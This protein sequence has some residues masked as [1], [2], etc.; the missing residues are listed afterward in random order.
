MQTGSR[1]RRSARKNGSSPPHPLPTKTLVHR[2]AQS[3]H[4]GR[5]GSY[6]P[7]QSNS[8]GIR[9]AL[10]LSSIWSIAAFL[11]AILVVAPASAHEVKL[12]DLTLTDLWTRATPPQAPTAGG[13]LTIANAGAEPDRLIA[14]SSPLAAK[15]E[16]HVMAMKDSVMTMRPVEGGIEIPAGGKVTLEPDGLHIMFISPTEPYKEGGKLPVTLT[17]EK[18]GK[19]DTFLHVLAI[20][21]K[22]YDA[23]AM[24]KMKMSP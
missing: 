14:A 22:A 16:L 10:S 5:G 9:Q 13:Y 21:A 2:I 15:T 23:Q 11:L 24:S 19:V 3:S 7:R 1:R 8:S 20:G 18:A 12:G 6:S 4:K 17:F